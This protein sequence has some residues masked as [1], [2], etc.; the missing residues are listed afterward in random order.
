MRLAI[1]SIAAAV[2]WGGLGVAVSAQVPT[3]VAV[4]GHAVIHV[5]RSNEDGEVVAE[6][7]TT[8]MF[9]FRMEQGA[10]PDPIVLNCSQ[11]Q[12]T[13]TNEAGLSYPVVVLRCEGGRTLV[14]VGVD[15]TV[16]GK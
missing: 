14:L 9:A 5:L 16:E 2:L 10:R 11:A 7:V 13:R 1:G 8:P 15:M 6:S 12:E 4:Q 3:P